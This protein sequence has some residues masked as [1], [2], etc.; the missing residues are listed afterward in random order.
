[1]TIKS[2]ILKKNENSN[3][4]FQEKEHK[5]FIENNIELTSVTTFLSQFFPFDMQKVARDVAEKQWTTEDEILN[6]WEILRDSGSNI[7]DIADKYCK[8]EKLDDLEIK[9]IQN[10]ISFFNDFKQFEI[11][12]SEIKIFSKKFKVAGT[13]DVILKEKDT[14]R[15][16]I[17][18]WK[19]SRKEIDKKECYKMA[20]GIFSELPNNKYYKYSAQLSFYANILK[21]N[22]DIQIWDFFLVHLKYDGTY[23]KIDT[24]NLSYELNE[25]FKNQ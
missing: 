14:N 4:I 7:H 6:E 3:L 15:L 25:Y 10:V 8:N 19:T 11:I 22:Y 20:K 13:I 21:E 5:Y 16:F 17:L 12:A 24:I 9:S 1:M 23:K 18:D 2:K